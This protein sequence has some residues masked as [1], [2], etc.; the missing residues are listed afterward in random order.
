MRFCSHQELLKYS[1]KYDANTL[2]YIDLN[3]FFASY[4]FL[5][6]SVITTAGVFWL[7][8]GICLITAVFVW[9]LVPETKGKTLCEIQ[10]LFF[11]DEN[12]NHIANTTPD[13]SKHFQHNKTISQLNL[14]SPLLIPKPRSASV[15]EE[16]LF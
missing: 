16:K 5:L 2:K 8:A 10:E 4:F 3:S 11:C 14:G 15:V 9:K 1:S 6:Q 12:Q 7:F 13:F